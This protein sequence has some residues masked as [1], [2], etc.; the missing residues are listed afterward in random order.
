MVKRYASDIHNTVCFDKSAMS[1]V[2]AHHLSYLQTSN[3]LNFTVGLVGGRQAP[4]RMH[5]F[6]CAELGPELQIELWETSSTA[7]SSELAVCNKGDV[8]LVLSAAGLEAGMTCFHAAVAGEHA[9]LVSI[10]TLINRSPEVSAA[11]RAEEH[12]PALAPI[13]NIQA[14]TIF[15]RCK[16]GF[17]RVLI[18]PH[19]KHHELL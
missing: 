15:T 8:V 5:I 1:E 7:R 18:P 4:K 6:L 12:R 19:L 13:K 14:P 2:T 9:S 16:P 10:W 11:E 17:V 3:T